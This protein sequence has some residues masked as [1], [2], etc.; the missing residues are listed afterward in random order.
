MATIDKP[1]HSFRVAQLL[2]YGGLGFPLALVA[3]PLYVFLPKFYADEYGLSLTLIG[4]ILLGTRLLDALIDPALGWWID[5]SRHQS[6]YHRQI[7]LASIP[8]TVGYLALFHAPLSSASSSVVAANLAISLTIVYLGYSWASITHQSWAAEL[9]LVPSERLR[10]TASREGLGLI[11]VI[12]GA[13][14]PQALGMSALSSLFILT[15]ALSLWALL[16]F[17]PRPQYQA[18][19]NTGCHALSL[20]SSFQLPFRSQ[21]FLWLFAVFILNGIASAMP[22]SLVT[23]FV[24]DV[25]RAETHTG[26]F[27]VL[28][29]LAGAA[30]MPLWIRIATHWGQVPAWILSMALAVIAFVWAY[31]LGAG[32]IKAYMA[33]C[34]L[35]GLAL[36]ADLALPPAMLAEII[37]QAQH[38]GE[39]EGA[40]FGVWNFAAKLNLALAAGISLPLLDWVG[41]VPA[42]SASAVPGDSTALALVYGLIPCWVK[43]SAAIVLLISPLNTRLQPR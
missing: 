25:L 19:R 21:S 26:L 20:L 28:Y 42:A 31:G 27:L 18:R 8:L 14:A 38:K 23:F 29:F 36:G 16:Q 37:H 39:R 41:Y 4:G 2:S 15:L 17:A 6:T 22:A 11:G 1:T 13:A 9:S 33:I 7:L 5:K 3:L 35:S 30:G 24:A 32:D 43:L 12:L 40:Y 10:L 34:L